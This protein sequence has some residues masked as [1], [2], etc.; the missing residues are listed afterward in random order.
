[1]N[2]RHLFQLKSY[3]HIEAII[4]RHPVFLLRNIILLAVLSAIPVGIYLMLVNLSPTLFSA[5]AALAVAGVLVSVYYLGIWLF[6]FS[7]TLDYY[8]DI[9]VLTNDR[10]IAVEQQGLFSRTISETDLWL[11]Q[12]VTS[13]INGIPATIFGYGDLSVQTAAEKERFH[14]E[15]A[16]DPNGIRQKMLSLAE[17]DRKYHIGSVEMKKVGM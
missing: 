11:I 12:D 3:E 13:E 8:L 6:F 9:W 4:R 7:L 17:E 10:L 14:F 1:M 2:I 15:Q 5:P 16:H